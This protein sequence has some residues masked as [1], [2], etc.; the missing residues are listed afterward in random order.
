[1]RISRNF[2]LVELLVVVAIIGVLTSMLLPAL[3]KARNVTRRM[4]CANNLKQIGGAYFMY[5]GDNDETLPAF[6]FKLG[7]PNGNFLDDLHFQHVLAP[8]LGID[9]SYAGEANYKRLRWMKDQFPVFICPDGV[10]KK[11]YNGNNIDHFY[12]QNPRLGGTLTGDWS[13]YPKTF[14]N[15]RN[16]KEPSRIPVCYDLRQNNGLSGLDGSSQ[17]N[18]TPYNAHMGPNGRNIVWGDGHVMFGLS[19]EYDQ[20]NGNTS[21]IK[22]DILMRLWQ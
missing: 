19:S 5:A 20:F 17:A 21:N 12:F 16:F 2:S 10:G 6:Y 11:A 22:E 18:A 14:P 15:L 3:N 13:D 4:A 8:Y 9:K 7:E 1:M